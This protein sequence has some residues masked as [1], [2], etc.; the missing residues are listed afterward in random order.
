[1]YIWMRHKSVFFFSCL[2]LI[3]ASGHKAQTFINSWGKRPVF[4]AAPCPTMFTSWLLCLPGV[5]WVTYSGVYRHFY[6]R[7]R[8][9]LQKGEQINPMSVVTVN[10]N[11]TVTSLLP[12]SPLSFL[13]SLLSIHFLLLLL[14]LYLSYSSAFFLPPIFYHFPSLFLLYSVI[15]T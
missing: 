14:S 6:T 3:H 15:S 8:H 11:P 13:I 7:N 2:S 1:M 9:L 10:K 5:E 4:L 12:P